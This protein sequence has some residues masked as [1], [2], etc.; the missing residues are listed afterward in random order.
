ME[1]WDVREGGGYKKK[2]VYREKDQDIEKKQEEH[3]EKKV[4]NNISCITVTS[5]GQLIWETSSS[6]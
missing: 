2:R 3:W 5:L 1:G 6:I 4:N